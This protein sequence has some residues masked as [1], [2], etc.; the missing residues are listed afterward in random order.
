VAINVNQYLDND[1]ETE[2]EA[3]Q[4]ANNQQLMELD[5]MGI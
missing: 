4:E 3:A 1:E 5:G 2:V